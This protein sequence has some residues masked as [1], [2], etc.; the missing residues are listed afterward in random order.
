MSFAAEIKD[1]LAAYT[2]VSG[3]INDNK[4]TKIAEGTA[5]SQTGYRD[6]LMGAQGREDDSIVQF[7]RTGDPMSPLGSEAP[8]KSSGSAGGSH[9]G[10]DDFASKVATYAPRLAKDTGISVAAAT[11]VLGQLGHESAGLQPAINE[12]NPTVP[13]SRGGI[14]WSQWTGPRRIEFEQ[15]ANGNFDDETNYQFL[16]KELGGPEGKVLA[17]LADVNDPFKAGRIFTDK[18][19]RPGVPGYSSRDKW[20]QRAMDAMGSLSAESQVAELAGGSAEDMLAEGNGDFLVAEGEDIDA[21]TGPGEA[22]QHDPYAKDDMLAGDRPAGDWGGYQYDG[23][24]LPKVGPPTVTAAM[25]RQVPPR[26]TSGDDLVYDESGFSYP[27]EAALP[28]TEPISVEGEE[29]A[30][31]I[32]EVAGFDPL[33]QTTGYTDPVSAAG[34]ADEVQMAMDAPVDRKEMFAGILNFGRNAL[35]AKDS[36]AIDTDEDDPGGE[37]MDAGVGG[38]NTDLVSR[39]EA[40]VEER[41]PGISQDEKSLRVMSTIWNW[42]QRKGQPEKAKGAGFSIY[43]T[44]KQISQKTLALAQVAASEGNFDESLELFAEAYS[45]IPD[46]EV[47]EFIRNE[48]GTYNV[49][50]MTSEG[51]VLKE[52]VSLDPKQI[53]SHIME[54]TPDQFDSMVE[55]GILGSQPADRNIP[56]AGDILQ[57]IPGGD[58]A[59]APDEA[60]PEGEEPVSLE[61]DE[62]IMSSESDIGPEIPAGEEAALPGVE[63]EGEE[64]PG[65]EMAEAPPPNPEQPQSVNPAPP[66]PM[67]E[68]QAQAWIHAEPNQALWGAMQQR[69]DRQV[70]VWDAY[71]ETAALASKTAADAEAGATALAQVGEFYST[72]AATDPSAEFIPDEN[73]YIGLDDPTI[74]AMRAA[75]TEHNSQLQQRTDNQTA[76]R[77]EDEAV[78][79]NDVLENQLAAI[80]TEDEFY[81]PRQTIEAGEEDYSDR[82][83]MYSGGPGEAERSQVSGRV[84]VQGPDVAMPRGDEMRAMGREDRAV[85]QGEVDQANTDIDKWDAGFT[86]PEMKALT[87]DEETALT[88][89]LQDYEAVLSAPDATEDTAATDYL[90]W[91]IGQA[92]T[93]GI[94]EDILQTSRVLLGIDANRQ[95]GMSDRRAVEAAYDLVMFDPEAPTESLFRAK[96]VPPKNG[97]PVGTVAVTSVLEPDQVVFMPEQLFVMMDNR[98][99]ELADVYIKTKNTELAGTNNQRRSENRTDTM[100]LPIEEQAEENP[101]ANSPTL[102]GR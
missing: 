60:I 37:A 92:A 44:Y 13:G 54:I 71:Q 43:Q 96:R 7:G 62:A 1:F 102:Q 50:T 9:A 23:V 88:T 70:A 8:F 15:F 3:V 87:E 29:A 35:G 59:G 10:D 19:L 75:G 66:F 82:S 16:L 12:T 21:L 49:R 53:V 34:S 94:R 46:G 30:G 89:A 28:G 56:G 27:D 90:T 39:L 68:E 52:D 55:E 18:F 84:A 95:A 4:R 24:I 97:M 81:S 78:V 2:A 93:S 74:N 91:T 48:D 14:G 36:G 83:T 63:P 26:D 99:Q 5:A 86:I 79:S 69:Y 22:P 31:A 41:F 33:P 61:G 72:L 76:E 6:W 32:S 101:W 80:P 57:D 77:K 11:G 45:L 65:I 47:M 58:P 25:A 40:A 100:M 73:L 42:W 85:L 17:Q 51:E 64:L 38:V 98:R 20:T 67:S